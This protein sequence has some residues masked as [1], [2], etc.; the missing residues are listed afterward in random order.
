VNVSRLGG[1]PVGPGG[2]IDIAQNARKVVFCGTF[3]AKGGAVEM[4]GGGLRIREAGSVRKFVERVEQITY[5][6]GQALRRGHGA[7]YVTE[8]AV[9]EL[10]AEGLV[11]TEVA[12]GIDV[13]RDV[14]ERMAFRPVIRGEPKRM[15][16]AIFAPDFA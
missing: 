4:A 3:D 5:S 11:L 1:V 10:T 9:F 6:A 12:P 16:A 7:V 13:R 2:F 15:D 8:R 14:L